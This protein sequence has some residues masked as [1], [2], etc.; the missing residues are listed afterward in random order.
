MYCTYQAQA[1]ALDL[2]LEYLGPEQRSSFRAT[3]HF[4]VIKTGSRRSLGMLLLG[5]PSFRVYR[6]SRGRYP[7]TL[8]TSAR[9]LARSAPRYGYCVHSHGAAPQED[10]LLS[11]KLLIEHDE[12]RFVAIAFRFGRPES[13]VRLF[14]D[15]QEF[16]EVRAAGAPR[17]GT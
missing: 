12:P 10:E 4:D 16:A 8:F 6:L 13:R 1:R 14:A 3:G 7:V 17:D 5:Y 9:Q 11:L 2:L 15:S